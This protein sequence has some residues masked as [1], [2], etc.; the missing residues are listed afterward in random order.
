MS[1]SKGAYVC[2][3]VTGVGIRAVEVPKKKA[4]KKA[5][6]TGAAGAF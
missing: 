3:S 2:Q 5:P 1:K 6:A 4:D